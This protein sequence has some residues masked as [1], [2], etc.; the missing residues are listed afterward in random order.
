MSYLLT[1]GDRG[2]RLTLADSIADHTSDNRQ[3][4]RSSELLLSRGRARISRQEEAVA[5]QGNG[6]EQ[7]REEENVLA[8]T[9]CVVVLA[10]FRPAVG[11]FLGVL[12]PYRF[13]SGNAPEVVRSLLE[14][15]SWFQPWQVV[16]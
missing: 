7:A 15:D 12:F 8:Y 6:E 1:E 9:P 2:M 11:R 13:F 4:D 5:T 10:L 3:Y 14:N 16:D